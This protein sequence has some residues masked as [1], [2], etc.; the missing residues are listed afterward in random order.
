ML[1]WMPIQVHSGRKPSHSSLTKFQAQKPV[2]RLGK[3]SKAHYFVLSQSTI[4]CIFLQ[5]T[6]HLKILNWH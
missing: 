1:G 5:K 4:K 2:A 6:E 3:T